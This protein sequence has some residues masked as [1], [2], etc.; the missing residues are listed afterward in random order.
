MVE[1][2]VTAFAIRRGEAE[3][4]KHWHEKQDN[5]EVIS[6][7]MMKGLKRKTQSFFCTLLLLF[8]TAL[9]YL[10]SRIKISI[11]DLLHILSQRAQL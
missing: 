2:V 1:P 5:L 11:F 10:L 4:R 9:S 3:F 8:R 6:F 7:K